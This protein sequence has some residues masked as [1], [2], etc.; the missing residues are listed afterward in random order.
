MARPLR[1]EFPGA[2]YHVTARGVA[3]GSV[4]FDDQDRLRF[5]KLLERT[6]EQH[7][8][9][10]HAYCLMDNHYHL[11]VETPE[12]NLSKGMQ[13][14]GQSYASF[15]NRRHGRVGHLYQGRF[16]SVLVEQAR[17]LHELTRYIHLN[18]VRAKLVRYPAQYPWSSY[19]A[20]LGATRAPG[21]LETHATLAGFG[22]TLRAARAAYRH[23]VEDVPAGDP[24][25]ELRAGL[26]LGG[27][28]FLEQILQLARDRGDDLNTSVR[29]VPHAAAGSLSMDEVVA[30]VCQCY[31]VGE[32]RLRRKWGRANEA[33]DVAI[34]L[35]SR[36]TPAGLRAIGRQLGGLSVPSGSVACRRVRERIE[37]DEA[38]ADR[39]HAIESTLMQTS[40]GSEL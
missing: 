9:I 34:Y 15:V 6:H 28:S 14:L 13:W 7:R 5:L 1:V 35:C 12:G 32:E 36:M 37:R 38:F 40:A 39:V 8:F 21:W 16:R 23:F 30:Q 3:Q 29:S 11:Q 33:R 20:Y 18:P 25:R 2:L 26:L 4:F 19:R 10:L 27:E 24:L 17:Y 22:P 31:R